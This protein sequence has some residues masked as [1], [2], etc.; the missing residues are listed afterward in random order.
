M[1]VMLRNR[2][3]VVVLAP[4]SL[5]AIVEGRQDQVESQSVQTT[6]ADEPQVSADSEPVNIGGEK[7]LT[8]IEFNTWAW[9]MGT[10][11]K[12]GVDGRAA[13]VSVSF[14]DILDDSDSLMAFAGHLEV[15][16]G[17]IAF[18]VDGFYADIGIDN[19]SGPLGLQTIDITYKQAIIDFGLMYRLGE[20]EPVSGANKNPRKVTLDAYAGVRYSGIEVEFDPSITNDFSDRKD[21]FDPIIGAKIVVPF[22][23][24]WHL[25]LNGDIGGFGAASEVT[26][27][28]TLVIG[29]DFQFFH[30][31][32]SVMFG[33]R[34]IGWQY[35]DGSGD[36]EF[37]WDITQHG[38]IFGFEL[39]F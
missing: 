26:W 23:E 25:A 7:D 17:K 2:L 39:L 15:G 29:Y 11:G 16:Y 34:A 33:Y 37:T 32:A 18:Y 31:P 24:K 35:T 27:S 10:Y 38:A 12:M 14:M 20:W 36:K 19:A 1:F 6:P 13:R 8:R 9:L 3:L 30:R 22:D 5:C 4:L 21:W 28:S